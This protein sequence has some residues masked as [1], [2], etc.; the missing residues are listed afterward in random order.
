M[1][2]FSTG[3]GKPRMSIVRT[4]NVQR[5]TTMMKKEEDYFLDIIKAKGFAKV[6]LKQNKTLSIL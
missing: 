4:N 2:N 3:I 6:C 1:H 5:K